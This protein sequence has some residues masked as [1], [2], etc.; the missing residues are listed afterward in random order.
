[1]FESLGAILPMIQ[2]PAT[3]FTVGAYY[4]IG[5]K[6]NFVRKLGFFL[7]IA[8]NL[9]WIAYAINPIQYGLIVTNAAILIL[10]VRGYMNNNTKV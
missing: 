4:F 1:M 8:G 7:G 10:G 6:T 2:Y 9:V 5:G 3:C